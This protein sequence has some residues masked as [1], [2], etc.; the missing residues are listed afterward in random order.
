MNIKY[1]YCLKPSHK[2]RRFLNKFHV[3]F[4]A[5]CDVRGQPYLYSFE[6]WDGTDAY[7]CAK[8][9]FPVYSPIP[10][11]EYT[12][13]EI[14]SAEWLTV[15]ACSCSVKLADSGDTYSFSC[16]I[17]NPFFPTVKYRHAEQTGLFAI[18]RP[19]I[20]KNKVFGGPDTADNLIFCSEHGKHGLGTVWDGLE[21]SPVLMAGTHQQAEDVFQLRFTNLLPPEAIHLNGLEKMQKCR[22]CGRIRYCIPETYQLSLCRFAPA[23][24]L[25]NCFSWS[26]LL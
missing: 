19:V 8:R 4:D 21:Y 25:A 18:E 2:A 10:S 6:L 17:K 22:Q 11:M 16:P 1:H 20:W 5:V 12:E 15:K 3:K 7:L 26:C 24:S 14:M 23:K 9:L 13:H